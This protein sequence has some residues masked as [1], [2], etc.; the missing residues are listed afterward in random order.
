MNKVE[1]FKRYFWN[2]LDKGEYLKALQRL[3]AQAF[4]KER[5]ENRICLLLVSGHRH[6]GSDYG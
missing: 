4:F 2:L 5:A 6:D 3:L 1:I